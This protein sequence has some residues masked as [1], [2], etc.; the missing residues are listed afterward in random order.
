MARPEPA[1]KGQPSVT[2]SPLHVH[3]EESGEGTERGACGGAALTGRRSGEASWKWVPE[4][5]AVDGQK[6]LA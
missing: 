6:E 1:T 3:S 2:L 4:E 5:L